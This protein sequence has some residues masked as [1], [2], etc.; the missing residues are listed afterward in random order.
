MP[1]KIFVKWLVVVTLAMA[2]GL[3]ALHA[4]VPEA[5]EHA[6]FAVATLLLFIVICAGLY[7]AGQS[8]VRSSQ[9]TAFI[10][11]VSAS[12]FGKM[13]VAM[14]YLLLYRKIAAP[15][16]EWYVYLF[17]LT[18]VVYTSFEVWFMMRLGKTKMDA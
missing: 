17:L 5:R 3:A 14:A 4:A 1:V 18:Y 8:A 11:L 6:G 16:N 13:V 9:K 7:A 2:A 15:T 12:V 10:G